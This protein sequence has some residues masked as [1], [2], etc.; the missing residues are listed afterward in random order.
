MSSAAHRTRLTPRAARR[1]R[2]A[3]AILCALRLIP[4]LGCSSKAKQRWRAA[5]GAPYNDQV[6]RYEDPNQLVEAGM[7]QLWDAATAVEQLSAIVARAGG[8]P[9]VPQDV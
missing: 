7:I 5:T 9:Q 2:C 4:W 3:A 6:P 1:T 8:F